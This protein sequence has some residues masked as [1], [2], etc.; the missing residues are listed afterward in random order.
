MTVVTKGRFATLPAGD[1]QRLSSVPS[2]R[3]A[4]AGTKFSKV[5]DSILAARH[6]IRKSKAGGERAE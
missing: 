1:G 3:E 4:P 2:R 5:R 6:A